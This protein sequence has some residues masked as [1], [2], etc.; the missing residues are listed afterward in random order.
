VDAIPNGY[1][2]CFPKKGH[3][4][5]GVGTLKRQKIGLKKYLEA[6]VDKLGIEKIISSSMHGFQIPVGQRKDG[7]SK[8]RVFLTGD[9]AGFADPLTAEGISN[10]ILSGEL[11]ATAIA[12][13]FNNESAATIAYQNLLEEKILSDLKSS[14]IIAFICYVQPAIRN[15]LLKKFGQRGCEVLTDIFMGKKPFPDDIKGKLKS[16]VPMLK[17]D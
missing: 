13:N 2:W 1:A 10:A 15:L 6:Y 14:S 16:H 4:S 12:K 5:L 17:F 3:L 7:F 11:A 9:A 8:D